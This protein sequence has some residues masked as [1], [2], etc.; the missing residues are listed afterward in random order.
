[1]VLVTPCPLLSRRQAEADAACF[2]AQ[3]ELGIGKSQ[4]VGIG[5]QGHAGIGMGFQVGPGIGQGA[6]A[7][8]ACGLHG[9][10]THR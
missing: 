4:A 1:M 6:G 7:E 5:L 10:L 3:Q 8:I 2:T 9:S